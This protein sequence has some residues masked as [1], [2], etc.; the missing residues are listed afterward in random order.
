MVLSIIFTRHIIALARA[1][2]KSI[3]LF[4]ALYPFKRFPFKHFQCVLVDGLPF[5]S[6]WAIITVLYTELP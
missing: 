6:P 3:Y 5:L 1:G 4:S 2:L